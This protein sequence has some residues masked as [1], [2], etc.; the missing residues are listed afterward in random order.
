[1]NLPDLPP[2]V[3]QPAQVDQLMRERAF[4]FWGTAHRVGDLRRLTNQYERAV[5]TVW[6]IGSYFKGGTFGTHVNLKPAQAEH[7]NRA[8][9]DPT[10]LGCAPNRA[11]FTKG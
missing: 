8:Y 5:D 11:Q 1:M 6:P 7:N 2:A 4:W 10:A 3:G 9:R